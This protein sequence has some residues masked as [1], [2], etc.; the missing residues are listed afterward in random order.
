MNGR[1]TKESFGPAAAVAAK[2]EGGRRRRQNTIK[3]KRNKMMLVEPQP[4]VDQL[5]CVCIFKVAT[6]LHFCRKT[7]ELDRDKV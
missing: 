1:R 6:S 7:E 4:K 3:F 5:Q 2:R